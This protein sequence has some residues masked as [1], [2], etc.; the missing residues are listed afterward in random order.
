MKNQLDLI[1]SIVA[2]VLAIG[3]CLTFF[4]TQRKPQ[5]L[6]EPEKIALSPVALPTGSVVM[7]NSLPGGGSSTGGA[8]ATGGFGGA[9]GTRP[10]RR[11]SMANR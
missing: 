5:T 10:S 3:V 11:D 2:A 6:P 8:P 9:G 7:A 1:V 4:F